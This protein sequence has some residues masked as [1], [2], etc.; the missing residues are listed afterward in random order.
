MKE[1][2]DACIFV[3]IHVNFDELPQMASDH[4]SSDPTPECQGMALK[5]V[6]LILRIQC[7][8]NVT[9]A[10]R[11]VTTSNEL[12]LLFSPMFDELLN[13]SSKVVSKSSTVSTPDALN[14]RQQQQTPPLNNHI[15]PE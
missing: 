12:D 7:Q 15:T 13:G 1:K 6:S 4:V 14:Q 8:E 2:G 5:H 11:T 10:D 3:G 9:Q